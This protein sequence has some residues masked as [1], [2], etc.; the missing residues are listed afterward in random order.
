MTT[1]IDHGSTDTPL[2]E[3]T[4]GENLQRQSL[5]TQTVK[6]SGCA[7]GNPFRRGLSSQP[8]LTRWQRA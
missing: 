7:P 1:A 2:L 3:Q 5:D 8:Q 4:I 6:P